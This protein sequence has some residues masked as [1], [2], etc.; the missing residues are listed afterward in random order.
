MLQNSS[1]AGERGR[2]LYFRND[3]SVLFAFS[4]KAVPAAPID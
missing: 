3:V 1:H 4:L 2:G